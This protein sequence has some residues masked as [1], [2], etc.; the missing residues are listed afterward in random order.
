M[1]FRSGGTT[2]LVRDM[3]LTMVELGSRTLVVDAN[4]LSGDSLLASGLP[5]LTDVLVGDIK[6]SQAL[7]QQEHGGVLINVVPYGLRTDTGIKRLDILRQALQ[8]WRERFDI[9]LIDVP[10]LLPSPDA[11]LLIDAI[12]QVFLVVEAESQLKSDVV[13]S[14]MQL[15]RMD[16]EAVGLL[17]NRMPMDA[18][19]EALKTHLMETITGD[20]FHTYLSGSKIPLY[21]SLLRLR[22]QQWKSQRKMTASA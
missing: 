5:G 9:V 3:A 13:R 16:P 20:R 21:W 12:G 8:E 1:L 18:G 17:V 14:R 22:L 2:S 4:S 19:G 7:T 11:E 15:Q 6:A 10:P